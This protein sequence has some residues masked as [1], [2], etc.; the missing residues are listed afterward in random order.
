LFSQAPASFTPPTSTDHDQAMEQPDQE[1]GHEHTSRPPPAYIPSMEQPA[2]GARVPTSPGPSLLSLPDIA[3]A[4]IASFLPDGDTRQASRLRLSEVSR[5]QLE[6]YGD[7]L[8]RIRISYV[9]DSSAARLV[10]LLRRQTTLA[11][12]VLNQQEC[13]P[14]VCEA[15]VQGCCR[16]VEI[17]HMR[18]R[19]HRTRLLHCMA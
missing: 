11:E 4:S 10:A 12:I 7:T 5:A 2:P 18:R 13:V 14:G 15:I 8:T 9:Q 16:R 17:I 1:H 19:H 6:A 3:H